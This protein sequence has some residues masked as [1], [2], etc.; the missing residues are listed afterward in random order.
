M[1]QNELYIGR[2]IWNRR[3]WLKDPETGQRRYVERPKAEWQVREAP[4]LRIVSDEL[5]QRTRRARGPNRGY[6]HGGVPT[7]LF[8]GLLRC[9]ACQGAI[10]ATDATYYA[11]AAHKDRGP[12]VCSSV[13][14]WRRNHVDRRLIAEVRSELLRPDAIV[15]LR[16]K[17]RARV[18]EAMRMVDQ[19]DGRRRRATLQAEIDRLVDAT[20]RHG[21]SASLGG[22]LKAA[23]D[24]LAAIDHQAQHA[25][26]TAAGAAALI[27][28]AIADYRALLMQL[29]VTLAEESDLPRTRQILA[30]L[31]GRVTLVKDEAG[32]SFAELEDPA[33]RLLVAVGGSTD[34]GGCE[35]RI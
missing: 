33:E 1:L 3:Q 31:L 5:W 10:V 21:Y 2:V 4:E 20:A 14:S 9:A 7:T 32:E 19:V 13:H 15:E 30:S 26:I 6:T 18:A 23:E 22:R 8:G 35:G 24:E 29:E 16:Q 28:Q 17:V 34:G 25:R 12:A 27:D 11:C